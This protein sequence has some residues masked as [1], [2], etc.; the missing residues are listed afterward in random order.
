MLGKHRGLH[1]EG[2]ADIV[3]QHPHPVRFDAEHGGQLRA[4]TEDPLAA[5]AHG[6]ALAVEG[7]DRPAWLHRH[8]RDA[9]V[10]EP[11]PRDVG[12]L[13][14]SGVDGGS[15]AEAPAQRPIA[16]G[17]AVELRRLRTDRRG[18]VGDGGQGLDHDL[19][20]LQGIGDLS[21]RLGHDQGQ[22]LADI[23]D[24]PPGECGMRW[25]D[26]LLAVLALQ[27][28]AAR[29]V[30][31]AVA[32]EVG[33][34]EHECDAGGGARGRHVEAPDQAVRVVGAE[35]PRRRRVRRG[36]VVSVVSMAAQ[37]ARVLGA[38]HRLADPEF[39]HEAH[40]WSFRRSD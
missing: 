29:Q 11:E 27:R 19:D 15:I 24:T 12:S 34:R 25:D 14:Q 20:Q 9:V 18:D 28:H 22:R 38:R 23:V 35:E 32:V 8:D 16:G 33:C 30:P 1:P 4:E 31:I 5:G 17:V 37:Q 7:D 2:A 21:C 13:G 10:G 36:D 6:P 39:R 3:A 40:G 26:Q